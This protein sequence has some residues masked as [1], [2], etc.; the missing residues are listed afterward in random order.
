MFTGVSVC[1][2]IDTQL[3]HPGCQTILPLN[4]DSICIDSSQFDSLLQF[5][6]HPLNSVFFFFL[7]LVAPSSNQPEGGAASTYNK[8]LMMADVPTIN[9]KRISPR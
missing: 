4:R 8:S 9:L 5:D 3:L 2:F 1:L 6:F 7:F